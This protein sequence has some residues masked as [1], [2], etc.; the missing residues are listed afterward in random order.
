EVQPSGMRVQH[1]T[2]FISQNTGKA[3]LGKSGSPFGGIVAQTLFAARCRHNFSCM[4]FALSGATGTGSSPLP[5][6]QIFLKMT[7]TQDITVNAW[8][9]VCESDP[10][11]ALI[12]H[13]EIGTVLVPATDASVVSVAGVT[14]GGQVWTS[15]SRGPG[16]QYDVNASP[17]R[18]PL[19]AHDV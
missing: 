12:N 14:S 10:L 9:A 18:V 1:P 8:L 5:T 6:M 11:T 3:V 17:R 2:L 15:S 4:V 13:E 7:A 19:M 16:A